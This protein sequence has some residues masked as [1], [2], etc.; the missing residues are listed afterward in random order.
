MPHFSVV[1]RQA[2]RAPNQLPS[3]PEAMA[4]DGSESSTG[5][6]GLAHR[7]WRFVNQNLIATI[8]GGLITTIV[9]GFVVALILTGGG[10][11]SNP[12]DE[13]SVEQTPPP[14]PPRDAV[15]EAARRPSWIEPPERFSEALGKLSYEGDGN[16]PYIGQVAALD[17]TG[18]LQAFSP[19]ELV[20]E[21]PGI[22][23]L[24]VIVVGRVLSDSKQQSRFGAEREVRIGGRERS[25][26][27]IGTD[28]LGGFERGEVVYATGRV[29]ARGTTETIQGRRVQ[30]VYFL[31]LLNENGGESH[32][33]PTSLAVER[34][35]IGLER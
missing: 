33:S 15:E 3:Y 18:D 28:G 31:A 1:A 21:A 26:V 23:G 14:K 11:E 35:G 2:G 27:L 10:E 30:A 12:T 17:L 6:T 13:P 16:G 25:E 4:D 20:D 5:K 7:V 29:A 8:L 9:G 32:S 22:Q 24:P 19:R 34:S